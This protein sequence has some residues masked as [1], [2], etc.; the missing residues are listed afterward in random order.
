MKHTIIFFGSFLNY[1]VQI[2]EKLHHSDTL[3]I[4]GIVTTPPQPSSRTKTVT[5]TPVQIYADK[6]HLP[7]FTPEKLDKQSLD[8]LQSTIYDLPNLFVVA[9][10][11]KLLPPSWLSFPKTA[12]INVHFSLLPKYRG[13]NPAEWALL[14][15]ESRT[16]VSIIEMSPEF[17]T[18]NIISQASLPIEGTDTRQTLYTKLY[19]LGAELSLATLPSYLEFKQTPKDGPS[20]SPPRRSVLKETENSSLSFF[21]PPKPQP[22]SAPPYARRLSRD[23]AFVPWEI[24]QQATSGMPLSTN[25]SLTPLLTEVVSHLNKTNP[26]SL[27]ITSY[28]PIINCSIRALAGF[29]GVWT[30]VPTTKGKKR[31]KLLSA[32]IQ[33][34]KLILDQVQLEGKEPSLF[35]QIKNQ[36]S[37][38]PSPDH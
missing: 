6:H 9:G 18:G 13:A 1:S 14:M 15:G 10:Y 37:I 12:A 33:D 3:E 11:G 31:L 23:D 19:D 35:N 16:G 24:I 20:T 8:N 30:K 36:I 22:A 25:Q 17:D 29:P 32:H 26:L 4:V 7:V 5:P 28:S 27:L 38:Q 21:L 2:L 34:D